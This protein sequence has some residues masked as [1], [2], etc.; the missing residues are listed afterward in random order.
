MSK[1]KYRTL[2]VGCRIRHGDD[3]FYCYHSRDSS[4][5]GELCTVLWR[6]AALVLNLDR[7]YKRW[8]FSRLARCGNKIGD[9]FDDVLGVGKLGF[10][11]FYFGVFSG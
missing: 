8:E 1:S 6:R 7:T 11:M 2:R 3:Q 9:G 4:G 10:G 5:Y